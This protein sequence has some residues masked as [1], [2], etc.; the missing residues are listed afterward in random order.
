MVGPLGV[1]SRVWYLRPSIASFC[2]HFPKLLCVT[3]IAAKLAAQTDNGN[4]LRSP[5]L[6]LRTVFG[7]PH[8]VVVRSL[9]SWGQ[10]GQ[11]G[12]RAVLTGG[13]ESEQ[14]SL[15]IPRVVG[16]RLIPIDHS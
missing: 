12:N 13:G 5:V 7:A 4:G 8:L 6:P 2:Q 9:R 16:C 15:V 1:E 3:G 10:A 11:P 14:L